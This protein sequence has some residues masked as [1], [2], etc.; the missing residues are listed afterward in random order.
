MSNIDNPYNIK[1]VQHLDLPTQ[2]QTVMVWDL[3]LLSSSDTFTVPGL[4]STSSLSALSTGIS[5]SAGALTDGQNTIT[6]T[7]G[8]AGTRALV[9]TAHRKGLLNGLALDR[10]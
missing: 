9:A 10:A 1:N 5:V 4:E 3:L 8:S 7:G 6:V 2:K